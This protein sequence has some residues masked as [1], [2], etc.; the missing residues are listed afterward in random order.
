MLVVGD[1][2]CDHYIWGDV[3]RISPEAPVQVL[4]WQREADRPGGAANAAMNL[5]ALGCRVHLVG[6]V[7]KDEPGRW[8]LDTLRSSGVNTSGVVVSA[9]RATTLKTRVIARGQHMLRIDRETNAPVAP[10]D[11][12]WMTAAIKKLKGKVVG[13]L[14]SDYSKGVL[15]D[16]VLAAALGDRRRF[17]AV[18]P[19]GRDFARY[20]GADLLTPNEKELF[21][22]LPAKDMPAAG[23]DAV[24]RGAEALI[25]HMKFP[26]LLVTRGS[27]GMDLFESGRR[28]IRRTHIAAL[29]RHEVFDVTGAGDTVAAVIAMAAA[30]GTPLA[31]AARLAN[32]AAGIVVGMVGTAVADIDTLARVIDGEASQARSK[33]LSLP[34]IAARVSDARAHGAAVVFTSGRFATLNVDDLHALQRA[35]AQGD[36]LVVGVNDDSPLG[37]ERAEMLAALRFVDYVVLFGEKTPA[38][39]IRELQP[40]VIV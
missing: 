8:L 9:D 26:A 40:D 39:L 34:A 27:S 13:V 7:G 29:Q 22:A 4:K 31:E 24:G 35:R 16:R 37:P 36:L 5:A 17:S 30:A 12:R 23:E 3:D 28:G 1:I 10:A 33:V 18:D 25:R 14:C 32:A 2:M 21:E 15:S 19:K 11:D 20:R 38:R 6:V